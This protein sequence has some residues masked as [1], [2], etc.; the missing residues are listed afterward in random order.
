MTCPCCGGATRRLLCHDDVAVSQLE[1][2]EC[3]VGCS[4]VIVVES[5]PGKFR[6]VAK[7][8]DAIACGESCQPTR[9]GNRVEYPVSWLKLK[10]AGCANLAK[11]GNPRLPAR[12]NDGD[13][14]F[15]ND[16]GKL[17]RDDVGQLGRRLVC[18]IQTPR[19]GQHNLPA[20]ADVDLS[21]EAVL[22][23]DQDLNLVPRLK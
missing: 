9:F 17:A 6:R 19:D 12:N 10:P 22:T 5:N 14:W 16:P 11:E 15:R 7:D 1:P 4:E 8:E 21:R 20:R 13:L 2:K 23:L 3:S 18:G